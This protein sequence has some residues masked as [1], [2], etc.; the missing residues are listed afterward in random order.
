MQKKVIDEPL[1]YQITR[2]AIGSDFALQ[3][4]SAEFSSIVAATDSLFGLLEIETL[5]DLLIANYTEIEH[6]LFRIA[7]DFFLHPRFERSDLDR[8]HRA[9]SR[10]LGNFLASARS[11]IDLTKHRVS[12]TL[13]DL[14]TVESFFN[15]EYDLG[16]AY[17]VMEALRNY[18]QHCGIAVQGIGYPWEWTLTNDNQPDKL[19]A[20][21]SPT[22]HIPALRKDLKFKVKILLELEE[23]HKD[24]VPIVPLLREYVVALSRVNGRIRDLYAPRREEW[25]STLER[26]VRQ[27]E[28]KCPGKRGIEAQIVDADGRVQES[29]HIDIELRERLMTLKQENSNLANGLR[30]V[31]FHT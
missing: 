17:R 13:G 5:Y 11:Y 29:V 14:E 27:Y 4:D 9:I 10:V 20:S 2:V 12:T 19:L 8:D 15:N 16:L 1:T 18:S 7:V 28:E 22:L 31:R 30:H 23:T 24:S 26:W 25:F 3:I 21:F 6:E